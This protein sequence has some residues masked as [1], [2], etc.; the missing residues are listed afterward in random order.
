MKK[1]A[2]TLYEAVFTIVLLSIVAGAGFVGLSRVYEESAFRES[3]SDIHS[4]SEAIA[5]QIA[6]LLSAS[7]KESIV[8]ISD[9]NG[10]L[11]SSMDGGAYN[12]ILAW[13]AESDETNKGMWDD[14]KGDYAGWN[15]FVDVNVSS[16]DSIVTSGSRIDFVESILDELTGINKSM[17]NPNSIAALYFLT[18]NSGVNQTSEACSEFGLDAAS[19]PSRLFRVERNVGDNERLELNATKPP[20]ISER[21]V[22]THTAHAVRRNGADN[23]LWLYSFR[24]WLGQRPLSDTNPVLL[25]KNVTGFGFKKEGGV[26]RI[27]VCVGKQSAGD[28][29]VSAC[30]ERVVF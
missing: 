13:V 28:Y 29:N 23:T 22:L 25:G 15:G 20:F 12:E 16:A 26:L 9:L 14:G 3:D 5:S 6:A 27:N 30:K 4:S 1:P 21:Y 18:D 19:S 24:P 11:C 17:Q 10:S 8:S 2:F 7:I